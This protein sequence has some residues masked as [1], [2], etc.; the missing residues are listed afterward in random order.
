MLRT[1][2]NYLPNCGNGEH[3]V[4]FLKLNDVEII[5]TGLHSNFR[6]CDKPEIMVVEGKIEDVKNL[7]S[8]TTT[9]DSYWCW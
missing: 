6:G 2:I 7:L 3:I 4:K 9:P 5:T 1:V 8:K